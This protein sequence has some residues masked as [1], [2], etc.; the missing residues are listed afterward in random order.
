MRSTTASTTPGAVHAR[1]AHSLR[2]P[3]RRRRPADAPVPARARRRPGR[4]REGHRRPGPPVPAVAQGFARP[5]ARRPA[6]RS[7]RPSSSPTALSSPTPAR[8]SAGFATSPDV[9]VGTWTRHEAVRGASVPRWRSRSA[10][11]PDLA[12]PGDDHDDGEDQRRHLADPVG[13]AVDAGEQRVD[14][15]SPRPRRQR[16]RATPVRGSCDLIGGHDRQRESR[17]NAIS[18]DT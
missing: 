10:R 9:D 7:S 13:P 14:Q 8:S 1:D 16:S 17:P 12:N 2:L 6:T 5:C 3:R 11:P 4:P 18:A 15:D